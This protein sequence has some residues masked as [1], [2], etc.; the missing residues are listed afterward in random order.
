MPTAVGLNIVDTKETSKTQAKT[1]NSV[2][3]K[4][5]PYQKTAKFG[6]QRMRIGANKDGK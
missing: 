5:H 1:G 6:L 4:I 3:K 2:R